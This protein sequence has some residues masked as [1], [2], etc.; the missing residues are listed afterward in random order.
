MC[1]RDSLIVVRGKVYNVWRGREFY[2]RGGSYECFAGTD[3]TRGLAKE[4][5]EQ[6][7]T[8]EGTAPLTDYEKM[9]LSEWIG[10]Y[11]WKYDVVG[12]LHNAEETIAQA[13]AGSK[14]V[15]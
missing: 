4:L 9:T 10:T 3:A 15:S 2:G 11:E 8:S 6:E 7:D 13:E 1:I 5:L 14:K 12:E